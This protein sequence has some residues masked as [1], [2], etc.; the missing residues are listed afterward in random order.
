[1]AGEQRQDTDS[2]FVQDV[3]AL[4]RVQVQEVHRQLDS[5]LATWLRA[6][7]PG[8]ATRGSPVPALYLHGATVEDVAIHT[9]LRGE[10]PLFSAT[11]AGTGTARFAPV[12]VEP[13]R[14]YAQEVYAATDAYLAAL[15]LGDASR[16]IDLSRLDL[17]R[18]TVAWVISHFVVL[19][20]AHLGGELMAATNI[21]GASDHPCSYLYRK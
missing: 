1:L 18:P 12:D 19:E 15:T 6:L 21:P 13:I 2:I 10:P 16:R 14:S 3:P 8:S 4:L 20:L 17:G 7:A 5:Y 11:W 9:L